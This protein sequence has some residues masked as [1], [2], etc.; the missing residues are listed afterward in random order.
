MEAHISF[1]AEDDCYNLYASYGEICTHCGCCS[2]D[3]KT[4]A[5]ARLALY[6]RRLEDCLKFDIWNEKPY[7]KELQEKNI[8]AEIRQ[9]KRHIAYYQRRVAYLNQNT[10]EPRAE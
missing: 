6:K 8:K 9:A 4:R 2:N 3:P 1:K 5:E 10:Q 7:L